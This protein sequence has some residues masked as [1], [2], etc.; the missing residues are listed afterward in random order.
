MCVCVCVD[1]YGGGLSVRVCF[2]PY[3]ARTL[4]CVCVCVCVCVSVSC[5]RRQFEI[6]LLL[7]FSCFSSTFG[8]KRGLERPLEGCLQGQYVDSE[9]PTTG[10]T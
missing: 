4:R 2:S 6:F 5:P 9:L 3:A 10:A 7:T 1:K 8:R